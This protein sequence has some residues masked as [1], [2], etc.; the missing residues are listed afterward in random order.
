MKQFKI[1]AVSKHRGNIEQYQLDDG[2]IIDTMTAIKMIENGE[3]PGY[4][5]GTSVNGEYYIRSSRDHVTD[6][7]LGNLP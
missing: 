6:N 2:R 3:L 4:D 5:K 1:V 7:N